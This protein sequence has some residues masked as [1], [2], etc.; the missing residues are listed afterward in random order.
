MA[1]LPKHTKDAKKVIEKEF[2]NEIA[3]GK[4]NEIIVEDNLSIIAVVGEDL[5][6]TPGIT[7][8]V[9]EA[10]GKSGININAI[11]HGSSQLN[12]SLVVSK[13]NLSESLNMLHE[14]LFLKKKKKVNVFLVGPG[15]VGGALLKIVGEQLD[16][17]SSNLN[18]EFHLA[19]IANSQLMLL[20]KSGINI[21]DWKSELSKSKTNSNIDKFVT[22]M[23]EMNL[24]NTILVDS[25]ANSILVGKYCEILN[26]GISIV[27]PNKIANSENYKKYIEIRDAASKGN[28]EFR[29]ETNVGAALPIVETLRDL[30]NNGDQ[31]I[32]IEGILSGTLSYIFNSL[33]LGKKFSEVVIDAKKRGFTE[34]DPR[35]DLSG[36]DIARKLLILIRESG[37][38]IELSDIEIDNLVPT[39]LRKI[40]NVDQFLEE[41]AKY[42]SHFDEM[43][44]NSNA[45]NKVL[46]YIAKYENGKAT[47][48]I[49]EICDEHPFYNLK[50]IENIVSFTTNYYK[51]IPL[52]IKG[53]G[54]GPEFTASGVLS[55]ILKI[56]NSK[57]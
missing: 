39:K 10:L 29:Y 38:E 57:G 15:V 51:E 16:Y 53:P 42:D 11:A 1:I 52:V 54:A 5:R 56:A 47:V 33:K 17:F 34:P 8:K 49:E 21:L 35:D 4:I 40:K 25:T 23:K 6:Q 14:S 41:L 22:I 3:D 12:L 2:K 32:K 37:N 48:K 13:D 46:A 44:L 43:R 20:N 19:G 30:I 31:L 18:T 50:G 24:Q 55:D 9:F 27:T 26:S 7:G 45:N 36:L 28:S